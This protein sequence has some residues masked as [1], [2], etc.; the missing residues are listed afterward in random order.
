MKTS[1]L[2]SFA[3]TVAIAIS[4]IACTATQQA[5]LIP[6]S[7]TR[8]SARPAAQQ[9]RDSKAH[10]VPLGDVV[11]WK[12]CTH[13]GD[14]C[15]CGYSNGE[16][17]PGVYAC[18]HASSPNFGIATSRQLAPANGN[19]LYGGFGKT[20]VVFKGT[21]QVATLTGLTGEPIGLAVDRVGNVWAT[22]SP[23]A[24]ISEFAKG[25]TKPTATYTDANLTSASYLAVDPAGGVYVEGQAADGIEV[26][27]LAAGSSTFAP[28]SQPGKVGLTAGGLAV[29][30]RGTTT[31]V[32]INDEGTASTTAAISRYVLKGSSLYL[33]GSFGYNGVNG[34]I[35]AD[36]SGESGAHVWAVN[37]VP[38]G[39]GFNTSAIEYAMPGGKIIA[40]TIPTTM[41]VQAVGVAGTMK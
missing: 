19:L 31:Y 37:N 18:L 23:A 20:V 25:A 39:S 24:T 22:D 26:D 32:W 15:E 14:S 28:I 29:Q 36:P 40:A 3:V 27:V 11:V 7:T 33:K 13:K 9:A 16:S 10:V 2:R 17:K 30:S 38:Y 6:A 35:W 21:K 1:S 41:S 8:Q 34:A 5:S 4:F 12:P